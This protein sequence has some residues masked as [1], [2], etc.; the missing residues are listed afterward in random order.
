[1]TKHFIRWAAV[2]GVCPLCGC[3]GVSLSN[4][5]LRYRMCWGWQCRAV[6]TIPGRYHT[7]KER[8]CRR[9]KI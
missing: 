1:M 8:E 2:K 4:K 7:S 5:P 6:F 3:E 9:T